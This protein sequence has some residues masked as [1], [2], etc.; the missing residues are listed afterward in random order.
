MNKNIEHMPRPT[1]TGS[2]DRGA[3]VE[4]NSNRQL[5]APAGGDNGHQAAQES[6]W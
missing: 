3:G 2:L 6:A 1:I 5:A 4:K